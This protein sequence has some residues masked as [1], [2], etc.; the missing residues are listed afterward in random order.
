MQDAGLRSEIVAYFKPEQFNF[1]LGALSP[2]VLVFVD[3][4]K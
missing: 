2:L 4:I 1:L 3:K